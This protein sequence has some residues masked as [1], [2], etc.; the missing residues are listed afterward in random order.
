MMNIGMLWLDAD[1]V[2]SFEEKVSRA[3][4][5]YQ[6]KYGRLPELCYVN[7][8]MLSEEKIVGLIAVKP[9]KSVQFNHFWLGM[10]T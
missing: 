3:A 10:K 5:Y 9:I 4:D 7:S 1:Q 8:K 2:R 6:E